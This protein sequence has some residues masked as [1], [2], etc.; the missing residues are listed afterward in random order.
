MRRA[1]M[2]VA[3][4]AAGLWMV[5]GAGTGCGPFEY[6]EWPEQ[7]SGGSANGGAA[8]PGGHGG[9]GGSG[10]AGGSGGE[11]GAGGITPGNGL[12]GD[13]HLV[14]RY[15][16]NEDPSMPSNQVADA[17]EPTLD[18]TILSAEPMELTLHEDAQGHRGLMWSRLDSASMASVEITGTKVQQKLTEAK[19]ATF[20]FVSQLTETADRSYLF[21]I[22]HGTTDDVSARFDSSGNIQI[23]INDIHR[24]SWTFSSSDRTVTHFVLDTANRTETER[25]R[26]Y[27]NGAISTIS[28]TANPLGLGQAINIAQAT[29]LNIG[30]RPQDPHS[31]MGTIYYAAIYSRALELHEIQANADLLRLDDDH[32]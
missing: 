27:I 17:S 21:F 10:G 5:A 18:M 14:V 24:A 23:R 6:Q 11:G 9:Q 32:P 31:P 19:A 7:G 29:H 28:L 4:A 1:G 8:G 25:A 30:N 2:V 3:G 13:Q 12:Q 22:G 16:I 26:L 20:E 15:F